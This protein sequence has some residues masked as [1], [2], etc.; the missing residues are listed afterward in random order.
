MLVIVALEYLA[1][2]SGLDILIGSFAAGVIVNLIIEGPDR[3]PVSQKFEAIGY[4]FLVPIFVV[5]SG[6]TFDVSSLSGQPRNL[7]LVPIFLVLPFFIRGIPALVL[8]RRDLVPRDRVALAL[9]SATTLPLV[10]VFTRVGVGE[11]RLSAAK[12]AALVAA[13]MVS[14]LVFPVV[15]MRVRS[16]VAK[17]GPRDQGAAM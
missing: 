3:E 13:G 6:V 1:L 8:F 2:T 12:G 7:A 14:V 10:V 17:S 4:G 15:A 5:V 9:V 16:V 11:G